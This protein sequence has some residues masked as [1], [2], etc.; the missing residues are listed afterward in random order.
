[1]KQSKIL[2][3]TFLSASLLFSACN[4]NNNTA[5]A[6]KDSAAV[7]VSNASAANTSSSTADAVFSYNLDGTK[8]SGGEADAMAMSNVAAVTKSNGNPDKLS[9]FL[10]D[11]YKANTETVAHS[12]RFEIPDKTGT[13]AL[14]AGG[15][16]GFVE[17]FLATDEEGKYVVYGN[18]SFTV[19][20]TNVSSTRV[21]GTFSGKVKIAPG[22]S[23]G[24][25]EYTITDGKFD[26]PIKP[27]AH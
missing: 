21:S 24:K 27:D 19:T 18:E 15:D 14:T 1:M 8:I 13:V 3:T 9:F 22:Q 4:A 16:G 11:A 7:S 6:G 2:F 26:I 23:Q 17:L 20:V 25:D 5:N 12:L 10:N